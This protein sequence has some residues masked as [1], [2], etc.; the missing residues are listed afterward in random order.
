MGLRTKEVRLGLRPKHPNLKMYKEPSALSSSCS[1]LKLKRQCGKRKRFS[2]ESSCDSMIRLFT[3]SSFPHHQW[4]SIPWS[5]QEE[6]NKSNNAFAPF[7]FCIH[8][9]SRFKDS[10]VRDAPQS[11]VIRVVPF[12][13]SKFRR[14]TIWFALLLYART[15]EKT[16]S[17]MNRKTHRIEQVSNFPFDL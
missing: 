4:C 3:L 8:Q 14:F 13:S 10:K 11:N 17:K 12:L 16:V 7:N 5:K 1:S 15:E 6:K 2:K 9:S